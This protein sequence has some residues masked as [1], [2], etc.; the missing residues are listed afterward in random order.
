MHMLLVVLTAF[1]FLDARVDGTDV[2]ENEVITKTIPFPT[3]AGAHRIVVD[4]ISGSIDVVGYDGD[5]IQ[6][7]A[8]RT[9]FG[10]SAERLAES[11]QKIALE[12]TQESGRVI[13]FVNT[14]WRCGDGTLSYRRRDD[15]GFDADF[16]FEIKVPSHADFSLR[17]VNK[18][19]VKV[20]NMHGAFEVE[21]VNGGI[22]MTGIVGSG[23]ASTVNGSVTVDFKKNPGSRCG[24][25]TV[26]GSIEVQLPDEFSADVRL[27]T[28]NGEVYT[29]FD[30]TGLPH[31]VSAREKIGRRTVY[32][33]DEY[34]TV[35]AGNGGPEMQC[36]TLNGDIRI[37]RTHK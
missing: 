15:A 37:L 10:A 4:N 22:V 14:P 17:T 3:E 27:K 5:D 12:V 13:I 6:L 29:D 35:R 9:S 24:F 34:S 8:R 25:R 21:N 19:T 23:Q 26:N 11:K 33:G 28:F 18:G 7:V 20:T 1:L 36:E 31:T 32:K 16:D 2:S 30:V